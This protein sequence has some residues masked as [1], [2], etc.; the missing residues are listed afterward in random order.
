MTSTSGAAAM[1]TA[2]RFA[3]YQELAEQFRQ[4]PWPRGR[5]VK[6]SCELGTVEVILGTPRRRK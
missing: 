2:A 6:C 5:D 1:T 4:L 3:P